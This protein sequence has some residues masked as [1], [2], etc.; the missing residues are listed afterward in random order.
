VTRA[1]HLQLVLLEA[2]ARVADADLVPATRS[3]GRGG[4]AGAGGA[5][6]GQGRGGQG[7]W[8]LWRAGQPGAPLTTG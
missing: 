3:R 1:P 8:L 6:Q 4:R 2:W 5:G 7:E